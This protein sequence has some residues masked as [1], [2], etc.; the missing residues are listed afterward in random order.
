MVTI[1]VPLAEGFEEIEAVNIID[2]VRRSGI[3]V[4]IAS[5]DGSKE[6]RGIHNISIQA[7]RAMEGITADEI[8]MIVL[9]GGW[10]G[11][12]I[13]AEDHNVQTLLK[14]M[15]KKN[16]YISAI[17][18]APFAL[19]KAGVLKESFT[20]YPSVEKQIDH[21][22]YIKEKKV[23][24]DKNILTSQGPATAICFA[25]EIIRTLLGEEKKAD[26]QAGV[27]ADFCE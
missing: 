26:V 22:G 5:V 9:P 18:A 15:D 16:K 4:I 13:L 27:L 24:R 8:D 2:V 14:E 12:K 10:G 21:S 11:T 19:Q 6:V 23:V 17:C 20:C 1:V 7:D 25:L 3:E